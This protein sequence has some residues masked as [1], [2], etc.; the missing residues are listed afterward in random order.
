MME[1]DTKIKMK[2]NHQMPHGV[3]RNK[4]TFFFVAKGKKKT[5]IGKGVIIL[6]LEIVR[7]HMLHNKHA[8]RPPPH[9]A[10]M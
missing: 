8:E 4:N 3:G 6:E 1:D 7:Y 10:L 9:W 5:F 2:M